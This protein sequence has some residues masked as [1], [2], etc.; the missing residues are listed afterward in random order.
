LSPTSGIF[1]PRSKNV[2]AKYKKEYTDFKFGGVT[3][4]LIYLKAQN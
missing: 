3:E 4:A 2:G 1:T